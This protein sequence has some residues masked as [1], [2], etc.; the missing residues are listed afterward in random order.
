MHSKADLRNFLMAEVDVKI[1]VSLG[2]PESYRLLAEGFAYAEGA[3]AEGD[4]A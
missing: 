3:V 4:S 2:R 1:A